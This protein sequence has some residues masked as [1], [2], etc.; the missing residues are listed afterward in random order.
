MSVAGRDLGKTGNGSGASQ[1]PGESEESANS[2]ELSDTLLP[3]RRQLAAA[4]KE[5]RALL[6]QCS[7]LT[8]K[9]TRLE[10]ALAKAN[11]FANYDELTGLPNRRLLLDRFIQAV[12]FADR[13][14]QGLAFL[15]FDLNDFKRVNDELGHDAGDMLLKQVAKRLSGA[16]R[17]SDTA[18]RYG[19]D[20]FVTLLTEIS[21][22]DDAIK[23]LQKIRNALAPPYVVDHHSIRVTVSDGLA[24]YPRD[25]QGF[26]D[27]MRLADRS[28]YGNKCG[29]RHQSGG[30]TSSRIWSRDTRHASKP[31]S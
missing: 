11:Q 18:C 20:E 16:V 15:F 13:H 24:I 27:L 4:L 14:C 26:T 2:E 21:H 25:G 19:G 23:A 10:N 31:A 22:G 29:G 3:A 12:A 5:Q 1:V 6:R 28:M 30:L 9:V 8:Y 17:G 7:F